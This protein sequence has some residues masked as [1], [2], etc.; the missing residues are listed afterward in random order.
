MVR[1]AIASPLGT[2]PLADLVKGKGSVAII[3]DDLTRPTPRKALLACLLDFLHDLGIG[4][5]RVDVLIG[6]GT[7]YL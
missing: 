6:V 5:D 1:E 3:V 4:N 2:P 7:P